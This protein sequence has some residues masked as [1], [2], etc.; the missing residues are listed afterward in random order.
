MGDQQIY[1]DRQDGQDNKRRGNPVNPVYPCG[2]SRLMIELKKAS[3]K[4]IDNL[5]CTANN[6]L[7][8]LS[9]PV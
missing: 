3:A 2:K 6:R 5:K 7:G 8:K 1:M 9:R 4:L